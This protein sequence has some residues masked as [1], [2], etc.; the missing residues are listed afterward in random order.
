MGENGNDEA[1]P[2]N[3]RTNLSGVGTHV[4]CRTIGLRCQKWLSNTRGGS[5]KPKRASRTVFYLGNSAVYRAKTLLFMH[6][7]FTD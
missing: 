6:A 2:G 7:L 5:R 1:K 3:C 4:K